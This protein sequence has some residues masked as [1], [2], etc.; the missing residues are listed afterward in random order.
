MF[1]ALISSHLQVELVVEL[2]RRRQEGRGVLDEG[3]DLDS[4]Y[5]M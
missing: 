4:R 1:V 2:L 3:Q 5:T